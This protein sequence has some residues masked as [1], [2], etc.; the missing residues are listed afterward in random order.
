MDSIAEHATDPPVA[1]A[2]AVVEQADHFL[3]GQR[4]AGVP[5]SGMWEF[6]GGK[7]R[8]DELPDVAAVRECREETGLEVVVVRRF[9]VQQHA[10][11]HGT[12]LLHFFHCRPMERDAVPAA[13]FVWVP[14]TDLVRYSFPAANEPILRRLAV[15][16]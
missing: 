14:R 11:A 9:E 13:P 8:P 15:G 12:L 7:I 1:V 5:L 10:Y 6:P 16:T 2:I 4:P 3:I